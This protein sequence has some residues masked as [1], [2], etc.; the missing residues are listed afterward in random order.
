MCEK[1]TTIILDFRRISTILLYKACI[2][3]AILECYSRLQVLCWHV[4][5][6]SDRHC[7]YDR[8]KKL[9]CRKFTRKLRF[10]SIS[11]AG[12]VLDIQPLSKGFSIRF[13]CVSYAHKRSFVTYGK[14]LVFI[15]DL[16]SIANNSSIWSLYKK[17]ELEV[18]TTLNT[19]YTGNPIVILCLRPFTNNFP[20][21]CNEIS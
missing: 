13:K 20:R 18:F 11:Y 14:S 21:L 19:L 5:E 6:D 12:V 3:M 7:E 1:N 4:Q 2:K 8:L 15:F 16:Q 10:M 9:P 17:C